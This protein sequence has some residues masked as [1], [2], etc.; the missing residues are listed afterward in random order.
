MVS[1]PTPNTGRKTREPFRARAAAACAAVLLASSLPTH[2]GMTG[3][4]AGTLKKAVSAADL[5]CLATAIYFE[6]RGEPERGQA[7]VAQVV[8][9]RV[10]SEAYPDSVCGVVYQNQHRRNA[11]QFS[12]ACDGR[13]ET[14]HEKKAWN[15]AREIADDVANGRESLAEI[16]TATHYHA[17]S[18]RPSWA[19]RLRR[20][21]LIGRHV[22]Y[23]G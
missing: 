20:V 12:F 18:V 1:H 6:A 4:E 11:C 9:N 13:A 7:A 5:R 21:G 8:L 3:P 19:K 16:G 22:F 17:N 15:K 23:R 2:A 10:E 14:I